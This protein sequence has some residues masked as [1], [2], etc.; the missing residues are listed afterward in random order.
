M[1]IKNGAYSRTGAYSVIIF[2]P[3]GGLDPPIAQTKALAGAMKMGV[4][5]FAAITPPNLAR[6]FWNVM[7][8]TCHCKDASET[9]KNR[10]KPPPSAAT[11]LDPPSI[12]PKMVLSTTKVDVCTVMAPFHSTS[13]APPK[14]YVVSAKS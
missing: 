6:P 7:F 1:G 5:P 3:L 10:L 2:E 4:E 12:M 14:Q 8:V 11:V 9:I 13:N